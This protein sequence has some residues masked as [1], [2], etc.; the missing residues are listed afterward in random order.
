MTFFITKFDAGLLFKLYFCGKLKRTNLNT[1]TVIISEIGEVLIKKSKRSRRMSIRLK[2]HSPVIVNMP[3]YC[4]FSQGEEYIINNK[5]WVL[6]NL[7]KISVIEDNVVKLS[8]GMKLEFDMLTI[9]IKKNIEDLIELRGKDD[10]Y[11]VLLPK[12][13]EIEDQNQQSYIKDH[14]NE[15]F[16]FRAKQYLPLRTAEIAEESG[17]KY[18]KITIKNSKSV[19][20]SCSAK[21]NI[22]YSLHLMRLPKHLI[23]Y[24]I[25]HELCH[26]I[27]KNHGP[28][29]KALINKYCNYTDMQNQMKKYSTRW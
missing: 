19:W 16:R 4:S 6:S 17:F 23:D 25:I 1:K 8:P 11:E 22:N 28:E 29:F 24:I 5:Q 15:V 26:T 2:P 21:N 12:N 9:D 18:N 3:L 13:I 7:K 14:I 10:M 20:G 27:V